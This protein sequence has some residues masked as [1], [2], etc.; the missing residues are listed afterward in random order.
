MSLWRSTRG[1]DYAERPT[2]QAAHLKMDPLLKH[3]SL[4][5]R[6]E[7]LLRLARVGIFWSRSPRHENAHSLGC[8]RHPQGVAVAPCRPTAAVARG[9]QSTR[10]VTP[11][12]CPRKSANESKYEV[13]K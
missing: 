12:F 8:T 9:E 6:S 2:R 10:V 11:E 4:L 7:L 1:E 13:S 5:H 3:G